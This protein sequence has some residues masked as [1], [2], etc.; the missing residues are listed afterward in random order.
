MR[1]SI[2][3]LTACLAL[4]AGC[5]GGSEPEEPRERFEKPYEDKVRDMEQQNLQ[6][7]EDQKKAIDEQTRGKKSQ[8]EK[9]G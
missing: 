8:D 3:W 1:T 4:T 7:V 9:D 6:R 5:G 2:A